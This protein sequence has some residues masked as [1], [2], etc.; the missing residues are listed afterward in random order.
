MDIRKF[1][2]QGQSTV[3]SDSTS[4]HFARS[5]KAVLL[6]VMLAAGSAAAPAFADQQAGTNLPQAD[7]VQEMAFDNT[8]MSRLYQGIVNPDDDANIRVISTRS[9][10]L[11]TIIRSM[12]EMLLKIS[13]QNPDRVDRARNDSG[14][15]G[16]ANS[17]SG[18][19]MFHEAQS[20]CMVNA[21][22]DVAENLRTS[23]NGMPFFSSSTRDKL[24]QITVLSSAE[25][26]SVV[27]LHELSH[28]VSSA[29]GS[30]KVNL[31][32]KEVGKYYQSSLE[33]ATADLGVILYYASKEGTFDNGRLAIGALRQSLRS[34]DHTTTD[35]V[36]LTLSQYDAEQ[37]KGLPVQT[38]LEMAHGMIADMQ[39][40]HGQAMLT[41]YLEDVYTRDYLAYMLKNDKANAELMPVRFEDIVKNVAGDDFAPNVKA[42]AHDLIDQVL[43]NGL[44]NPELQRH[45]GLIQLNDIQ[46]MAKLME[47][48]L[49]PEQTL[50]ARFLD[51][52]ITPPGTKG[53]VGIPKAA[54]LLEVNYTKDLIA[55]SGVENSL[56]R[57][58]ASLRMR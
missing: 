36:D 37:F 30:H 53:D 3:H 58:E 11:N 19:L 35:M 55:Q 56:P 44:R 4:S 34:A 10:N 7:S 48:S 41:S 1:L 14:V 46:H 32:D 42:K 9:H 47:I 8:Y 15:D 25:A 13:Q 39:E 57:A 12:P 22:E 43:D 28:C 6:S 23:S 5:A 20:V 40:N 31:A 27:M 18:R 51:Q 16:Y 21:V 33:E 54:H 50:K 17:I 2:S 45:I 52:S 24:S 26:Q 38:V 49:T 29:A